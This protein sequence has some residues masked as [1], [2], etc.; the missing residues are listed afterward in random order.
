MGVGSPSGVTIGRN[1]QAKLRYCIAAGLPHA[2]G[3]QGVLGSTG[4]HACCGCLDAADGLW[5]LGRRAL[6]RLPRRLFYGVG[7]WDQPT[8]AS[9]RLILKEA[10]ARTTPSTS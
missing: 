8:I 3:R 6:H 5:M 9:R 10:L 4:R 7:V 1:A 2:A